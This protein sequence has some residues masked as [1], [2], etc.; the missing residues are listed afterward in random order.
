M[1][2][3]TGLPEG[4]YCD[5]ISG[6]F[7]SSLC[8]YAGCSGNNTCSGKIFTVDSNGYAQINIDMFNT[9]STEDDGVVAIHI[10]VIFFKSSK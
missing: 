8:T 4:N 6:I 1:F 2:F 9:S 3:K 10:K 7:Q 5:V